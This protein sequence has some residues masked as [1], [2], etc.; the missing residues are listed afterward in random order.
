MKN[1][2]SFTKNAKFAYK[3]SKYIEKKETE[4]IVQVPLFK[5]RV[6]HFEKQRNLS[7]QLNASKKIRN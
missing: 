2:R 5:N 6:K 1:D 3:T 7:K 4:K